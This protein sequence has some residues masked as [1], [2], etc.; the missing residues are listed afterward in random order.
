MKLAK[1]ASVKAMMAMSNPL[2]NALYSEN[3]YMPDKIDNLWKSLAASAMDRNLDS[4]RKAYFA[5]RYYIVDKPKKDKELEKEDLEYIPVDSG[6][7][8]LD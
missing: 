5:L 6:D 7:G 1:S 2:F 3:H 4:A 8:M